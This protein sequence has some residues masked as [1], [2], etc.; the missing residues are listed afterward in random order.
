MMFFTSILDPGF[1]RDD[2]TCTAIAVFFAGTT[3]NIATYALQVTPTSSLFLDPGSGSGTT[4]LLP[5]RRGPYLS[6]H[7]VVPAEAGIQFKYTSFIHYPESP[8]TP[9]APASHQ[10]L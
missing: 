6:R 7:P 8:Q 3:L 9:V 2:V 1:R 4:M 10:S 5:R